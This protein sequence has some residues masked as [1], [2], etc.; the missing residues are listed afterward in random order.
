MLTVG[1]GGRT[2]HAARRMPRRQTF[3]TQTASHG[4][5]LAHVAEET[6]PIGS[7]LTVQS[8]YVAGCFVRNVPQDLSLIWEP[9]FAELGGECPVLEPCHPRLSGPGTPKQ[10]VCLGGGWAY[11]KPLEGEL[12]TQWPEV[13]KGTAPLWRI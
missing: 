12:V 8:N 2:A 11:I 4:V 6:V 10:C 9:Q 7:A 1:G 13:H 3:K 5:P